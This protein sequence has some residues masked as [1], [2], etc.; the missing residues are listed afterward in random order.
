MAAS[1]EWNQPIR[2][3]LGTVSASSFRNTSSAFSRGD[4]VREE[5]SGW[6]HQVGLS[7]SA[8]DLYLGGARFESRLNTDCLD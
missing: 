4:R 7:G 1:Y 6:K 5:H 8:S 2:F 3:Q